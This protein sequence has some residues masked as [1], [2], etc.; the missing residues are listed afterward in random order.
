MFYCQKVCG[1]QDFSIEEW[2]E[3]N[4]MCN[5]LG[6]EGIE[7]DKILNPELFPCKTQCFD[8]IVIVGKRRDE[9]N[10]LLIQ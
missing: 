5:K 6:I 7:R 3:A 9:T 1:D 8:C 2:N 4:E 10:K